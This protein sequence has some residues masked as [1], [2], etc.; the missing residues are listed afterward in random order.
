MAKRFQ[1]PHTTL[2]IDCLILF[3]LASG[4]PIVCHDAF[5]MSH[6]ITE[7]CGLKVKFSN[8]EESV[9]GFKRS[10]ETFLDDPSLV[11]K[12]S[13]GAHKRAE[14]LSWNRIIQRISN[15]YLKI[16]N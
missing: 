12:L 9:A 8:K 16:L 15:D 13:Q 10:L 6:A 5:G 3:S 2:K 7:N 14:E 11:N 1:L 4:L